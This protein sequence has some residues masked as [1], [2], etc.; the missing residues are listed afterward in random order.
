MPRYKPPLQ[1]DVIYHAWNMGKKDHLYIAKIGEG[2]TAKYFYT[3]EEYQAYMNS[4]PQKTAPTTATE[5]KDEKKKSSGSGKSGGKGGG[6]G[7]KGK[8]KKGSNKQGE[9]KDID[10]QKRAE[11][12]YK[13]LVDEILAGLHGTGTALTKYL[14]KKY[15]KDAD[16]IQSLVDQRNTDMQTSPK[17][18]A[19]IQAKKKTGKAIA[20]ASKNVSIK[21]SSKQI[22]SGKNL[23][24]KLR[25][26]K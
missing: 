21:S 25:K 14:K 15:G 18:K 13:N 19:A 11:K 7:K 26:K 23:V 5:E 3:Q 22:S 2:P 12:K 9:E 1:S 6:K 4:R 20:S 16:I 17:I 10:Y 8:A 24:D